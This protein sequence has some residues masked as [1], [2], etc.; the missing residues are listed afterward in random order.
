MAV[1]FLPIFNHVVG[2][3]RGGLALAKALESY[4]VPYLPYP[5]LVVDDVLTTGA[6]MREFMKEDDIGLVIFARGPIPENI[7][8][9]FSMPNI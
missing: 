8:A 5:R 9:L 1:E 7:T 6:S 2:I 4:K 3:P